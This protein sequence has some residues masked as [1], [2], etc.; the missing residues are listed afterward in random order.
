MA[1]KAILISGIGKL[2][3]EK[4]STKVANGHLRFQAQHLRRIRIP[5]WE[6]LDANTQIRLIDT[7]ARD[8]ITS[9]RELTA[10]IYNLNKKEIEIIGG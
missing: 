4:Y 9:A 7:G 10:Q 6:S 2:F 5:A 3:I 1:L 8:D